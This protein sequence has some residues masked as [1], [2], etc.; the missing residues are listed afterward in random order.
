MNRL[1]FE[2]D[3]HE[4]VNFVDLVSALDSSF[5]ELKEYLSHDSPLTL[6]DELGMMLFPRDSDEVKML[7]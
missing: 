1:C 6:F 7:E 4:L 2:L 5:K 3:P